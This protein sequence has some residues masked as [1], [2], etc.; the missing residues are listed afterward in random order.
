MTEHQIDLPV[1]SLVVLI[2]PAGAG[3]TTLAARLFGRSEVVSSDALRG[4]LSGDEADQR[5]TRPAFGILHREVRDRL[6]A[7]RLVVVDATN[8]EASARMALRRLAAAAAV[9]AIAVAIH[10]PP[11]EVH[12]RNAGR[13]G[14]VVP[15][16]VVDRHLA[17]LEGLGSAPATIEARL[18]AEGFAAVHVLSAPDEIDATSVRLVPRVE[19]P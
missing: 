10:L 7:G 11:T 14:R 6:A 4:V 8:V 16:D 19:D 5:A 15:P 13:A 1:P 3:K 17:L 12:R 18:R 2:G 9:P